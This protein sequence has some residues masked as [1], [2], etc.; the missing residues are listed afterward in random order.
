MRR[1]AGPLL[2]ELHAH[3]RWS[4]GQLTVAES[5]DLHG[6]LGF[7]VLCITDHVTR[8]DD[9]WRALAGRNTR[10]VTEVS[11]SA[12]LADVEREAARAS[13]LYGMLVLPGLELTYNDADPTHAAHAV[14]VG[15]REFVS[16]DDG[17][18]E[19]V[20]TAVEAG[21]AVIAAHPSATGSHAPSTRLTQRF[22][23]DEEL[24]GLVHRFELFNRTQLFAWIAEHGLPG[25]ATGDFHR[26]EHVAGWKTLVP[27]A[28]DEGSVVTHLRSPAPVYLARLGP[29]EASAAAA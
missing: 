8:C 19:A 14:A 1:A 10:S 13:A 28:R 18:T 12:Y 5:V 7:D 17:V 3:T 26:P 27:T 9:P 23:H 4:D 21:A 16:V 2:C 29:G 15:L 11:W 24:R 22:A 6:R 20:R 25:V